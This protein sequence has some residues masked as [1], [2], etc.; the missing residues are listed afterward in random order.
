MNYRV[1]FIFSF[2]I[3]GAGIA[4]LFLMPGEQAPA[5]SQENIVE[6]T[7]PKKKPIKH[8]VIRVARATE[9]LK[10]GHLIAQTSYEVETKSLYIE[11][12]KDNPKDTPMLSFDLSYLLNEKK[13]ITGYLLDYNIP[14]GNLINIHDLTPPDDNDFIRRTLNSNS[15]VAFEV[16]IAKRDE[17]LMH[18][19]RAGDFV[20]IYAELAGD[21]YETLHGHIVKMI[22]HALVLK[23]NKFH[24]EEER[25]DR[26]AIIADVLVRIKKEQLPHIYSFPHGTRLLILPSVKPEPV[27]SKGIIIRKLRG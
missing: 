14:K 17:Y 24:L 10:E 3:L 13:D 22:D 12:G 5:P 4:G 23:V 9:N 25:Q 15:E 18:S 8:V 21:N 2:L 7:V 1:L 6:Q 27:N 26:R 11:E 20:N 16:G 19:L